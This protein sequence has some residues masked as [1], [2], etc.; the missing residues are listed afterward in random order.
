MNSTANEKEMAKYKY[1]FGTAPICSPANAALDK[2][3]LSVIN[4]KPIKIRNESPNI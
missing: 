4:M 3:M 2:C 1:P